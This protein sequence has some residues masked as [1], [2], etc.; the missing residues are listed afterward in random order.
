MNILPTCS[1]CGESLEECI[2]DDYCI[3]CGEPHDD[4]ICEED[5]PLKEIR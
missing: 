5:W 3:D 2:C 1:G 4:H